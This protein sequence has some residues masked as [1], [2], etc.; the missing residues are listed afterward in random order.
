M[1]IQEV[2]PTPHPDP[3]LKVVHLIHR[4]AAGNVINEFDF[5]ML[6]L[7]EEENDVHG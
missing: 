5:E 1:Q 6:V 4:D 2:D 7:K 3:T